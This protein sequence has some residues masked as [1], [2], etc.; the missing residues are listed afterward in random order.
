MKI[1]PGIVLAFAAI[2]L[3]GCIVA[4]PVYGP[5]G[6][7]AH[8]ITC[9]GSIGVDWSDCFIKAGEICGARGYTTWNQSA[10]QSSLIS[11]SEGSVFG[12][13]SEDRALLI[14]CNGEEQE[15]ATE[16]EATSQ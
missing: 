15:S 14:S 9:S 12:G 3:G 16:D 4:K 6:R 7:Q 11:G 1:H 10:S 5:D 2:H 8:A 13:S